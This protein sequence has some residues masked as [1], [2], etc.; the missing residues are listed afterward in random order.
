[1][2]DSK[3]KL[4]GRY[5]EGEEVMISSTERVKSSRKKG[6]SERK[7]KDKQIGC[8][9]IGRIRDIAIRRQRYRRVNQ[10]EVVRGDRK[11]VGNIERVSNGKCEA[12]G[13]TFKNGGQW[14]KK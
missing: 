6:K 1:M 8:K 3:Y 5:G 13:V 7:R 14:Q 11:I 10:Q 9:T 4:E 2:V 12:E